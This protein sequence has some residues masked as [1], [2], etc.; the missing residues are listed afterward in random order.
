MNDESTR[1]QLIA[2][3]LHRA[4]YGHWPIDTDQVPYRGMDNDEART[5]L[6]FLNAGFDQANFVVRLASR[7]LKWDDDLK[8]G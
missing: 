3:V 6:K 7:F 2:N 8:N 4:G 5:V 1:N